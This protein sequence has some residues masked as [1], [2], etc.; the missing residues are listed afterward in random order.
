[1]QPFDTGQPSRRPIF[2]S[3]ATEGRISLTTTMA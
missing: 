2:S 1:M 3:I